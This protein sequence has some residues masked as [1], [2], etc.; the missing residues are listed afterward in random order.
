MSIPVRQAEVLNNLAA[1][2]P[3]LP[4]AASYVRLPNSLTP[5]A[6]AL[7]KKGFVKESPHTAIHARSSGKATTWQAERGGRDWRITGYGRGFLALAQGGISAPTLDAT[8]A[9][10]L[11]TLLRRA[12]QTTAGNTA[13]TLPAPTAQLDALLAYLAAWGV[14]YRTNAGWLFAPWFAK[15]DGMRALAL[16]NGQL[17]APPAPPT[18][19][20]ATPAK[21][22]APAVT[23]GKTEGPEDDRSAS[24]LLDG[25]EI[26]TLETRKQINFRPAKRVEFSE[27]YVMLWEPYDYEG[28]FDASTYGDANTARRAAL[29]AVRA[30]L[31]A[32]P[33]K[34][35]ERA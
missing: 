6:D 4:Q 26:G 17:A 31:A 22:K 15:N 3:T 16:I 8:H 7:E 23:S 35:P 29:N 10:L 27:V 25:V 30:H 5:I 24:I 14:V 1:M 2:D 12:R 18:V 13:P 28:T 33:V 19:E 34:A 21:K 20:A 32:R 11:R 9:E